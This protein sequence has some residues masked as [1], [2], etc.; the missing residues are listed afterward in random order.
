MSNFDEPLFIGFVEFL[1]KQGAIGN[2][3][4]EVIAC[5]LIEWHHWPIKD[6]LSIPAAHVPLCLS[7]DWKKYVSSLTKDERS[8]LNN[9]GLPISS[10]FTGPLSM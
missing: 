6:S 1:R 2:T 7:V 4:R 10:E 5:R 3:E 9:H 8:G